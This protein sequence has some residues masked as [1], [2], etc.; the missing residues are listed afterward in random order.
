MFEFFT[1]KKEIN[2]E[3]IVESLGV[4]STEIPEPAREFG[5]TLN[6]IR[7]MLTDAPK[8]IQRIEKEIQKYQIKINILATQKE[9]LEAGYQAMVLVD[10][11]LKP[12]KHVP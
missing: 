11:N 9:I 6:L 10:S 3:K 4:I 8:E 7:A 1:G 2:K 12:T 5:S